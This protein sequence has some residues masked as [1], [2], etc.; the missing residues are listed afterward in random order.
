[1]PKPNR[2][3]VRTALGD[4]FRNG[5]LIRWSHNEAEDERF[6]LVVDVHAHGVLAQTIDPWQRAIDLVT[7]HLP[8]STTLYALRP[9]DVD[10]LVA[11]TF[12]P[13]TDSGGSITGDDALRGEGSPVEPN[14]V[15]ALD[16]VRPETLIR[17]C[18]RYVDLPAILALQLR[19]TTEEPLQIERRDRLF[20]H[21]LPAFLTNEGNH[22]WIR[23]VHALFLTEPPA[24]DASIHDALTH[25]AGRALA[26]RY[27]YP[28]ALRDRSALGQHNV[29]DLYPHAIA[30]Q[31]RKVT[32]PNTWPERVWN[33]VAGTLTYSNTDEI[34]GLLSGY[35]PSR[36]KY[37]PRL[38]QAVSEA[39]LRAHDPTR[40]E[41]SLGVLLSACGSYRLQDPTKQQA[42]G[43]FKKWSLKRFAKSTP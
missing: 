1:M 33:E 29:S 15:R 12:L 32:D 23:G 43:W 30:N 41:E 24:E 31:A 3:T 4:A 17:L 42:M 27:V 2:S 8:W 28:R 13:P 11:L 38:L 40:T 34:V 14:G 5:Q 18:R 39:V 9:G 10:D 26:A 22:L 21:V 37:L 6:G 35:D 25:P 19:A 20:E 16:R 7:V 36:D